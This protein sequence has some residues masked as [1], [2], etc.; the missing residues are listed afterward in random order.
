MEAEGPQQIDITICDG[1][2]RLYRRNGD[3]P[4]TLYAFN[5]Y[6]RMY[7]H[8]IHLPY[9]GPEGFYGADGGTGWGSAIGD[10]V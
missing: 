4:D 10:Q 2:T 3:A 8:F 9:A 1:N 5:P 7:T 6:D